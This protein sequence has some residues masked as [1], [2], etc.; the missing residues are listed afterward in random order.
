MWANGLKYWVV[1]KKHAQIFD[2]NDSTK[3]LRQVYTYFSCSR[4]PKY[5]LLNTNIDIKGK[6]Y[7]E[8]VINPWGYLV[9]SAFTPR[10]VMKNGS[11][12]INPQDTGKLDSSW[13][14]GRAL[15]VTAMNKVLNACKNGWV[16]Q[17]GKKQK[18]ESWYSKRLTEKISGNS[19]KTSSRPLSRYERSGILM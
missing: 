16:E 17:Y 13:W 2:Q 8:I 4:T 19:C 6:A 5:A 11:D 12:M 10:N 18:M 15:E 14:Y 3:L 1:K 9:E 7:E